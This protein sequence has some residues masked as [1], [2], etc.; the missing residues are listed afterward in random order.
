MIKMK[1]VSAGYGKQVKISGIDLQF[2]EGTMTVIVG[3]NG[4]GKSTLIKSIVGLNQVME[5]EIEVCGENT[6]ILGH[7]KL[8]Q[9]VSYLSQ[10][11][12]LPS[13][14]ASKMVLHG[15][16]PYLSYPRHYSDTDKQY[17]REA[18]ERMGIWELR[19][20][21]V[22]RLSGGERQ[23]VYLAMALAGNTDILILDEPTTYLDVCYQIEL[24]KLLKN[25]QKEGKT[26]V[27]ILHDLNAALRYA[28][29]VVVMRE[30]NAVGCGTADEI[31]KSKILDETFGIHTHVF[32]DGEGEKQYYFN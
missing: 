21:E 7:K 24:M 19:N 23:K 31:Y 27:V 28:D 3:P 26:I 6:K 1:K 16:F 10:E 32:V 15:R 2:K 29:Q 18:M 11:R 17:V 9:M 14:T 13:I 12:N 4:S 5:G 20:E 30:G 25:L 22:A 8:A